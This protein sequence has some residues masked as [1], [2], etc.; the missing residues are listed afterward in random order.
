MR[1]KQAFSELPQP[2]NHTFVV[3]VEKMLAVSVHPDAMVL[4]LAKYIP[5][6]MSPAIDNVD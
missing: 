5:A 2:F 1:A 4:R 3:R 6:N